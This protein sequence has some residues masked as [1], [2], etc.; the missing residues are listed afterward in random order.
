MSVRHGI[1]ADGALT[2]EN[3]VNGVTKEV[4]NISG[5]RDWAATECPGGALYA[6]LPAIRDAAAGT[7]PPGDTTAPVISG[8]NASTKSRSATV[9]WAT[10]EASTSLVEY[11]RRGASA[12]TSSAPDASLSTSHTMVVADLA[13]RTSYE[14]RVTSADAAGNTT[15]SEIT[16]FTTTK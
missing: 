3:P 1:P 5:H 6:L 15:T 2:Y 10:D 7:P 4:A 12:W 11:R 16:A 9:R 13:R 14:Y 8:V